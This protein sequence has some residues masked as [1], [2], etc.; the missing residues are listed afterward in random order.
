MSEKFN[1]SDN[2]LVSIIIP[3][4]NTEKYIVKCLKSLQ[5][6]TYDNIEVII[7]NDGSIDQTQNIIS[8]FIKTDKRFL[9]INQENAGVSSARN[10]GINVSTGNYLI[11]VDSDDYV[12]PDYVETLLTLMKLGNNELVCADYYKVKNGVV[13]S[14][15]TDTQKVDILSRND[16]IDLLHSDRYFQGYLWNKIFLKEIVTQNYI[17]FDPEIKIWEDMQF[18]LK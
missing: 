16:A 17:S 15:S 13:N 1:A 10:V 5:V 12:A 6:Q 11:F 4:Y 14:H 7:V 2:D 3:A 8:A 18:C 9:L